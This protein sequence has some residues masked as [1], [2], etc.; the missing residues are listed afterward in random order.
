MRDV[1]VM[2]I[3]LGSIP[4]ALF[5]PFFGVIVWYW[6]AYFNP[7]RLAWTISRYPVA[8]MIAVPTLI[9]MMFSHQ[10][11]RKIFTRETVCMLLLWAWFGIT[12]IHAMQVPLFSGHIQNAQNT[13]IEVTKILLMTVVT[14][15]LVNTPEKLN[16]LLTVVALSFGLLAIKTGIFGIV[17][18]GPRVYGPDNSFIGDN[19]A[20]AL[21][22]NMTLPIFFFMAI[23]ERRL[24]FKIFLWG[25]FAGAIVCV[26]L[27]YSRGGL[28]ALIAVLTGLVLR[29]R[30]KFIVVFVIAF[31]A[32]VLLTFAPVQWQARMDQFFDGKLDSSAD[33]RLITW[34]TGFNLALHN[35]IFGGGFKDLDDVAVYQR[36]MPRPL[37]NGHLSTGP[38]SIYVQQLSE[39]GFV[40]LGLFLLLIGT[41]WRTLLQLRRLAKVD[42]RFRWVL[43]YTYMFELS[44]VAFMVGGAFLEFANFD[45]WY[46]I[47]GFVAI[48]RILCRDRMAIREGSTVLHEEMP[49]PA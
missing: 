1:L 30:K 10:L 13:Y 46:L 6:I 24:W 42:E 38:H 27:S 14:I 22:L 4:I 31:G 5:N 15:L 17:R 9:G 16:G 25:S 48:M 11:N 3:I 41:C 45:F 32:W 37:P 8:Q 29:S 47:V 20:F 23:N 33:E 12:L 2:A 26:I 34:Q 21:A 28:L 39:H 18:G 36:Y 49:V 7:H 35:P 40:G 44:I 43:S 19:N